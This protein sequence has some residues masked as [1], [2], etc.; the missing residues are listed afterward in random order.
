MNAKTLKAI[1]RHGETLLAAFPNAI[2]R[3]PVA[4]CK[5]LRRI[6]GATSIVMEHYCNGIATMEDADCAASLALMRVQKLLG[7]DDGGLNMAHIF[8]NRDPRGY[9]LKLDSD[10]D[11]FKDWQQARYAAKLPALYT[12]MGGYG[13]LAPDLTEGGR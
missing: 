1:T 3:D 10:G 5:K 13:I 9:A 11:W 6:E 4:L 8:I 2:E 7:L 12:D